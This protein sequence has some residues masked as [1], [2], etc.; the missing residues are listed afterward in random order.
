LVPL[1]KKVL[2]TGVVDPRGEGPRIFLVLKRIKAEALPGKPHW[3]LLFLLAESNKSR[4]EEILGDII[5]WGEEGRT[6]GATV[7]ISE[8]EIYPVALPQMG[9]IIVGILGTRPRFAFSWLWY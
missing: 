3:G 2:E 4:L 1:T 5:I 6:A 8:R 7:L 9:R